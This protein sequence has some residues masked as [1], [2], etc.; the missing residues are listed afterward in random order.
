MPVGRLVRPEEVANLM[1]FLAWRSGFTG[2]CKH[3]TGGPADVVT[4]RG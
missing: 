3:L 2:A 1:V 4:P